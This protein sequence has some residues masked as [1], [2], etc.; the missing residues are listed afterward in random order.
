MSLLPL[1]TLRDVVRHLSQRGA[2]RLAGTCRALWHARAE[3]LMYCGRP[4]VM[5]TLSGHTDGVRSVAWAPDGTRLASASGD[6]SVRVWDVVTGRLIL[7]LAGHD[8][9]VSSVASDGT[10][11]ASADTTVRM[12][13]AATGQLLHTLAGHTRWVCSVS[14]APD[15]ARLASASNDETARVWDALTGQLLHTLRGHMH[16]V[17]S[18]AWAPDGRRLASA[19]SD[20]T[21]L[22]W[23]VPCCTHK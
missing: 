6:T 13:D 1:V 18:V 12:W 2:A 8:M 23:D 9:M 7:T 21:V 16:W 15:G 17:L 10:R 4:C 14:W 19:A 3:L 5:R 11:L 22:V 20:Q